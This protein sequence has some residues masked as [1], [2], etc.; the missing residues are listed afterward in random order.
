[1]SLD[2]PNASAPER[3]K[4]RSSEEW[5]MRALIVPELRK[6]WPGA[7]IIHELPLR[8]STNRIDLAAVTEDKIV[9]V[10][11]KSSRDVTDRLEAQLRGFAPVSHR[12]IVALAP[13]WLEKPQDKWESETEDLIR[14]ATAAFS[15]AEVWEVDAGGDRVRL[16]G[17]GGF[18]LRENRPW[19][20]RMLDML[21]VEELK[22][23]AARHRCATFGPRARHDDMV[24]A[25][26]DLMTGR[27]MTRAVCRAL[28]AR[29]AFAKESDPPIVIDAP[30]AGVAPSIAAQLPLDGGAA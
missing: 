15:R 19:A 25:L 16:E 20:S 23:I 6:R 11:I 5:R 17:Y 28:R 18:K 24:G 12:I 8:Y 26:N 13:K 29:A 22:D 21:H 9:A 7:R 10:E 27:E 1:M 14:R 30:A 4:N 3:P 2:A